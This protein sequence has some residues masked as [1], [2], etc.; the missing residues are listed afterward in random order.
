MHPDKSPR[1]DGSPG[2]FCKNNW[3]LMS[4]EITLAALDFLNGGKLL[5][6]SNNSFICLIPKIDNP[7]TLSDYR[8]INLCNTIYKVAFKTIVNRLKP[9]LNSL[10]SPYQNGFVNGR[11]IQDSTII[12]QELTDHIRTSK[13]KKN[14]LAAIKIDMSK[15][16]DR[17]R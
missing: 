11:L 8:P 9:H 15:A 2:D 6:E 13:C 16:F 3:N 17:V 14:G 4:N 5:K 12:A 7:E 1:S 10:L